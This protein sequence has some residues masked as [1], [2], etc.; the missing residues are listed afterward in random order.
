MTPQSEDRLLTID[1]AAEKDY[2]YRHHKE[3]SFTV[4]LSPRQM[5]TILE[6]AEAREGNVNALD[7]GLGRGRIDVRSSQGGRPLAWPCHTI[8]GLDAPFRNLSHAHRAITKD[9]HPVYP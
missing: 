5:R 1:E 6:Q 3:I 2:L 4:R 9:E 7:I 8:D